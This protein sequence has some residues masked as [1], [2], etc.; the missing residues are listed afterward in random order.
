MLLEIPK[1]FLVKLSIENSFCRLEYFSNL[2]DENDFDHCTWTKPKKDLDLKSISEQLELQEFE[3]V[4]N[5][6]EEILYQAAEMLIY[7]NFCPSKEMGYF[8][9]LINKDDV[10]VKQLL[11]GRI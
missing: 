6:S 1:N 4:E 7:L 11:L 8:F 2:K 10:S 9:R 3:I 5:V